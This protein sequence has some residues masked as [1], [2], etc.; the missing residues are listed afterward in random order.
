VQP[1]KLFANLGEGGFFQN[2]SK[3]ILLLLG[4]HVP[5]PSTLRSHILIVRPVHNMKRENFLEQGF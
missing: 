2:S 5:L 1:S 3:H 4:P